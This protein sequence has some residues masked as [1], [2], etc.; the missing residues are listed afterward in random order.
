M[1]YSP[2]Q[3][4]S[5]GDGRFDESQ[6]AQCGQGCVF[7]DGCL[8][9]HPENIHLGSHVYVGHL[10]MLKGYYRNTMEI[11][12]GTWIGQYA[13]LHSAGGL[14]IGKHVGVGPAVKI[15]TSSHRDV[16]R[17]TPILHAPLDFAAVEIEDGADLG[18]GAI[19]LP[20]VRIGRGA[21]VGAGS[22]VTRD[23]PE[24]TVVAGNPAR[25]LKERA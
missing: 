4:R 13:F 18:V 24:Y 9:F 2:R 3:P 12:D 23:V 25:V 7:E 6:L 22:V 16:G 11:G 5:H 10:A 17:D 15:F 20:G 1:G 19:V 8:V 21:Q 14:I